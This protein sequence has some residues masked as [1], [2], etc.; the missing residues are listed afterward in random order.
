MAFPDRST[1]SLRG[2]QAFMLISAVIAILG[3]GSFV[4]SGIDGVAR[5]LGTEYP[6]LKPMLG[7]AASA[8]AAE[9]R[10]TFDHFYRVLGWYWLMTGV[11]LLWITPSVA[12]QTAWFRFIHI[13]F[14]AVG[15]AN[16]LSMAEYGTNAHLRS[17]ALVPELGVPCVA[18]FWQTLVAR[19]AA[20][21]VG[22][23][24]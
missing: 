8:M 21:G 13:A 22:A 17:V 9:P 14:M 20:S 15:V 4:L 3:G 6:A 19:S 16:I 23:V 10:V 24:S 12:S 11:M 7:E 18:M 1:I 2:L 5:V